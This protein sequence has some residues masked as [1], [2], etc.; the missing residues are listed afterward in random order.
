MKFSI[1]KTRQIPAPRK[2]P[3]YGMMNYR[4]DGMAQIILIIA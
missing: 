3:S 4:N 2:Y 1:R